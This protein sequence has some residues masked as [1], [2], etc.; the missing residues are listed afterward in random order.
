MSHDW[1][2]YIRVLIRSLVS[3]LRSFSTRTDL[4]LKI[5]FTY[6]FFCSVPF[7]SPP[8]FPFLIQTVSRWGIFF[9][10]SSLTKTKIL[11]LFHIGLFSYGFPSTTLYF[12]L[13]LCPAYTPGKTRFVSSDCN[14]VYDVARWLQIFVWRCNLPYEPSTQ[15]THPDHYSGL[16]LFRYSSEKVLRWTPR[17]SRSWYHFRY[18]T[19]RTGTLFVFLSQTSGTNGQFIPF[20]FTS[21]L[22]FSYWR[23]QA[24]ICKPTDNLG[25]WFSPYGSPPRMTDPLHY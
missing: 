17:C 8:L 15:P 25:K 7:H 3:L 4:F 11:S 1:P 9:C 10:I 16:R 18:Q 13:S 20:T 5:F 2:C 14:R 24:R 23:F 19:Y 22:L 12:G 6:S 21:H